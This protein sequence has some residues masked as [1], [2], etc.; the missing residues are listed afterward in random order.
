MTGKIERTEK[1][2]KRMKIM[3]EIVA[4]TSLSV[5]CINAI[6]CNCIAY[7]NEMFSMI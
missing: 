2:R 7:A 5:P 3:V 6:N 4:T 1:N